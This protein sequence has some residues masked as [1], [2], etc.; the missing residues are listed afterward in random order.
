MKKIANQEQIDLIICAKN[1]DQ[2]AINKLVKLTEGIVKKCS[3]Q[4]AKNS[5]QLDVNDLQG[6]GV[7]GVLEAIKKYNL[8]KKSDFKSYATFYIKYAM[9]VSINDKYSIIRIPR[10]KYSK[11]SDEEKEAKKNTEKGIISLSQDFNNIASEDNPV[12]VQMGYEE[13]GFRFVEDKLL[14]EHIL[15][16]S[17]NCLTDEEYIIFVEYFINNKRTGEIRKKLH[18]NSNEKVR[19][20]KEIAIKKLCEAIKKEGIV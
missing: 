3:F 18:Y 10:N 20:N 17:K 4:L 12:K 19:Q 13:D 16:I 7:V 6:D 5:H 14:V 1:G 11:L 8:D 2:E 9:I 15:R